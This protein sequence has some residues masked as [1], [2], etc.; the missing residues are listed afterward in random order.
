MKHLVLILTELYPQTFFSLKEVYEKDEVHN[1]YVEYQLCVEGICSEYF[2][3]LNELEN[4]I[5]KLYED[6]MFKE[7]K[8]ITEEK[9]DDIDLE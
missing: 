6:E 7:A 8:K 1:V 9:A 3:S 2:K 4:F 5:L